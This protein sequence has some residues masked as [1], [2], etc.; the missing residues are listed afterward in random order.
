MLDG[1]TDAGLVRRSGSPPSISKLLDEPEWFLDGLDTSRGLARFIRTSRQA[2]SEAVFLDPNWD[3]TG[4]QQRVVPFAALRTF[5]PG[6][7]PPAAIWHSAFCCSTLLASCLDVPGGALALKE[8]MGLVHLSAA[9]RRGHRTVDGQLVAAAWALLGRRFSPYERIL[10]K[11][12]NGAHALLPYAA[13]AGGPTLLLYSSCRDFIASIASGGPAI[14]GGEER[15]RFVRNLMAE[16]VVEGRP[17]VRWRPVDLIGL[18]DLQLAALLWHVHMAE[19]RAVARAPAPRRV[20]SLNCE[21]FLAD[22]RCTLEALDAFFN[23]GLGAPRIERVVASAKLSRYA[24]QPARAF[25]AAQRRQSLRAS[26]AALGSTLDALVAWS[27]EAC[28][29]TPPG[30]PVGAP[31]FGGGEP[32][33]ADG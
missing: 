33:P 8:P 26:E 7:P 5:R 19:F 6:A 25:D 15:R 23:L 9:V 2:L 24:K 10:V 16:R 29:E 12:S 32:P 18:T 11:P 30:D 17:E 1:A 14:A 4:V 3:R 28:P 27:Y 31:L 22:P 21:V 20:R 13:A